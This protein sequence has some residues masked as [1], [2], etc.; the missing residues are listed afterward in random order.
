MTDKVFVDSNVVIYGLNATLPQYTIAME[1]LLQRPV[2]SV[3]VI[4][5]T[6]NVQVRKLKR[7]LADA[8]EVAVFLIESCEVISLEPQDILQAI[9]LTR[10]YS[11]SHWD[12]LIVA[13]A[14]R[15]GCSVLYSE[16]MHHGLWVTPT[17]QILNPFMD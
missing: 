6:I 12:V 13:T 5:E 8:Q 11:L 9:E 1:L 15:A 10:Q 14:L 16:D 17:L 3:Q 2:I 7:S 4:N